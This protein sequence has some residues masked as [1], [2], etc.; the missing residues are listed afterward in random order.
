MGMVYSTAA[1]L[2]PKDEK[3]SQPIYY[4]INYT[5]DDNGRM[6]K[7]EYIDDEGS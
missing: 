6:V 7:R 4:G 2:G 3:G 1:Y 5:F